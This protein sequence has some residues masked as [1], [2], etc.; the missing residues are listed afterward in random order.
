VRWVHSAGWTARSAPGGDGQLWW[1]EIA[2]SAFCHQMV[3]SIVGAL[4]AVGRGRRTPDD[5][6]RL[7]AATSRDGAPNLAP[8]QGLTLWQV[9]YQP[10]QAT[11]PSS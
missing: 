8:P 6:A 2:A 3:R 11:G 5:V 7:L 4:V 1:F 9:G 10:W